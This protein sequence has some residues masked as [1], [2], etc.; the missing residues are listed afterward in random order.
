MSPTVRNKPDDGGGGR[1]IVLFVIGIC[2]VG[3]V[4]KRGLNNKGLTFLSMP[5]V[6]PGC[7]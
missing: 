4:S 2:V 7:R 5:A 6:L 3:E 1:V